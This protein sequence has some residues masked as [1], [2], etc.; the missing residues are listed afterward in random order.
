MHYLTGPFSHCRTNVINIWT[1][2]GLILSP[3]TGNPDRY[4]VTTTAF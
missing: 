4:F 2:S 3:L 1:V